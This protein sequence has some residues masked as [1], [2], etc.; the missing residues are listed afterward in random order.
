MT[1]TT[2]SNVGKNVIALPFAIG[3]K[4][5]IVAIE[6]WGLVRAINISAGDVEYQ[7]AYFDDDKVRRVEWLQGSELA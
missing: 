3:A 7:V 2:A 4:V 6:T 5:R 1:A